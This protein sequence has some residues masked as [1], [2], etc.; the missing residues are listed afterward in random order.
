VTRYKKAEPIE[1]EPAEEEDEIEPEP[2][3][4]WTKR[5]MQFYAGIIK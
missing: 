1:I 2:L 4:E 5:K 3:D